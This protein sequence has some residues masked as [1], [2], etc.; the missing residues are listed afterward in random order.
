MIPKVL[1]ITMM[2]GYGLTLWAQPQVASAGAPFSKDFQQGEAALLNKQYKKAIRLFEKVLKTKPELHAARRY[3]GICYELL[4]DYQ[5]ALGYYEAVLQRDSL[6]SRTLYFRAGETS[7]KTGNP[8]QALQYL[9]KFEMMQARPLHEF[10]SVEAPE[11]ERESEMMERLD[12]TIRACL[13][14]KDSVNF[15]GIKNILNLGPTI[16]SRSDE[17][18]PFVSN[19]QKLLFYTSR[20]NVRARENLYHSTFEN[21]QWSESRPINTKGSHTSHEGMSTVVRDGKIMYFTACNREGVQGPCDIMQAQVE[22]ATVKRIETLRGGVNSEKWES[23]ASVSCDGTTL[24]FASDREGGYGGT[25]I[26]VS[27]RLLDGSWSEPINLGPDINTPAYEES[28]FITN[29]GQTLYFSSD[30]HP[31]L[32]DQDI[33]MS[34]LGKDGQWSKPINLGPPVNSPHRE[35]CLILAADGKTGYFASDRPEGFG[36]LD[37]YQFVLPS[38]LYSEAITFV[39]GFVRDSLLDIPISTVVHISGHDPIQTDEN[40]RFFICVLAYDILDIQA[41]KEWYHPYRNEF[42]IPFWDNRNFYTIE[43]RMNPLRVPDLTPKSPE[44]RPEEITE[45][46]LKRRE[47]KQYM[48][49]IFFEFDKS[50]MN[51][52]EIS[53]LGSFL[54]QMKGKTI[55]RV[56]IIGFSDDTGPDIYNLKLSEERAKH[57]ALHLMESG[58]LVDQIYIEGRGEIRDDKPKNLNRKVEVKVTVLE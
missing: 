14:S 22:G 50:S 24:Y 19:D 21:G 45:A 8:D 39:E 43:I 28:P 32:G 18:F 47:R 38:E 30:G 33:F 51:A 17:Y 27:K 49:T 52:S 16:N 13:I 15:T 20:K 5:K 23:Q 56:E 10:S 35:L 26:W 25:D 42:I 40:G 36:G 2:L 58:L 4:G 48:H 31:G 7:Y 6:F 55:Q 29:D 1:L 44:P 37:I 54:Q 41:D 46:P 53:N 3:I 9:A 11:F 34:R 57:I 12:H